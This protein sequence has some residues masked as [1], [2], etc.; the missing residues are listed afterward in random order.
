MKRPIC[1]F[2]RRSS[3]TEMDKKSEDESGI[4]S[5]IESQEIGEDP[6]LGLVEN[7]IKGL[8]LDLKK[9]ARTSEAKFLLPP[10]LVEQKEGLKF[11]LICSFQT[12]RGL[13]EFVLRRG[14][15]PFEDGAV[16]LQVNRQAQ[17]P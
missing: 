7:D 3:G 6:S 1:I 11:E 15:M 13:W 2:F 14:T 4:K 17:D 5:E 12:C 8:L 9:K 16:P 10:T